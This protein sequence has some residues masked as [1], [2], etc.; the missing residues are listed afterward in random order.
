MAL[1][2]QMLIAAF[3]AAA[4]IPTVTILGAKL[5]LF[6][7]F[8]L[9]IFGHSFEFRAWLAHHRGILD[10]ASVTPSY[11]ISGT[12]TNNQSMVPVSTFVVIAAFSISTA[13]ATLQQQVLQQ[14][15]PLHTFTESSVV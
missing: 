10:S 4:A 3:L 2:L 9:C 12:I 15:T 6:E 11:V 5:G 7:P 8:Q 14:T 13:A 1:L